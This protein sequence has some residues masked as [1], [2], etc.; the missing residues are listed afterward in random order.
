MNFRIYCI[1]CKKYTLKYWEIL[2][3]TK[4]LR[5]IRLVV[6]KGNEDIQEKYTYRNVQKKER[7]FR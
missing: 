2:I 5:H 1:Y 6:I 7:G 3:Q 4:N